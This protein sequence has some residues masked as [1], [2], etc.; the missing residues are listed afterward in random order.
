MPN[1][2][3]ILSI[4]AT[5][6]FVYLVIYALILDW[7][8]RPNQVFA[9]LSLSF[10]VWNF[11]HSHL[12]LSATLTDV[13]TWYRVSSVGWALGP[14]L[15][16]HFFALISR[17]RW[18]ARSPLALAALYVAGFVF[19]IKQLTG[20]LLVKDFVMTPLGWDEVF[21]FSHGWSLAYMTFYLV[22][23]LL[24][25][26]M[27]W[28]WGVTATEPRHRKQ[29]RVILFTGLPVLAVVTFTNVVLRHLD[30]HLFPGLAPILLVIWGIGIW[31]A[32]RRYRLMA[33]TAKVASQ[34]IVE[35]MTDGLLLVSLEGEIQETNPATGKI[36]AEQ[37]DALLGK[38]ISALFPE[39]EA[40]QP[41]QLFAQLEQTPITAMELEAGPEQS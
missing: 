19:L 2:I 41:E 36:F 21:Y 34:D 3:A 32:V 5:G 26:G 13:W 22:C 27:V 18:F 37:P 39:Q 38:N 4:L 24:G 17:N 20:K 15:L 33:L 30:I 1:I 11:G 35:T 6:V 9:A 23:S 28:R 29:A 12:L 16:V 31:I 7:R 8:S 25:L 40:L 10:A 14:P